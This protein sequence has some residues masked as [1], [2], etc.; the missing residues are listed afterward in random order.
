[1]AL[2]DALGELSDDELDRL[3]AGIDRGDVP[4][5]RVARIADLLAGDLAA[6]LEAAVDTPAVEALV[7]AVEE[8]TG[9]AVVPR[10]DAPAAEPPDE[11]LPEAAR[12]AIE[13][14]EPLLEP[15]GPRGADFFLDLREAF[16]VGDASFVP[17]LSQAS[18]D[19]IPAAQRERLAE[20]ADA[21]AREQA[22]EAMTPADFPAVERA[23]ERASGRTVADY[24]RPLLEQLQTGDADEQAILRRE[25]VPDDQIESLMA[26]DDARAAFVEQVQDTI[27]AIERGRTGAGATTT[28]GAGAPGGQ[29]VEVED[30]ADLGEAAARASP[31]G[32]PSLTEF[33]E[34]FVEL[35]R[36]V[37]WCDV[38][39]C[40]QP[41]RYFEAGLAQRKRQFQFSTAQGFM[42]FWV[43]Q[44]LVSTDD[45]R[46]RGF[47][48]DVLDNLPG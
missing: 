31:T 48:D 41:Q 11:T 25:G 46:E 3:A 20:R 1:M 36:D 34:R 32:P 13:R 17:E 8:R 19:A 16:Q 2:P 4:D 42:N 43:L 15:S 9:R 23:V 24:W 7:D 22:A 29:A 47:D 21:L 30:L 26:A 14:V 44:G 27:Q 35:A 12:R 45:L 5:D 40:R 18:L 28:S 39:P 10:T 37:G 6:V 33:Q 38:F